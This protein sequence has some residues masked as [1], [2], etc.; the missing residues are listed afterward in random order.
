MPAKLSH[1]TPIGDSF[2]YLGR[3]FDFSLKG[4]LEKHDI[5]SKLT[6]LLKI[7]SELKIRPQTKLKIFDRFIVSQISSSLRICNFTATWVSETLDPLCIKIIR[8]WIEVAPSCSLLSFQPVTV[9]FTAQLVKKSPSKQSQL[10]PI[11]TWLLKQC[12]TLLAPFLTRL[13][14]ISIEQGSVPECM[15]MAIVAPLLKKSILDP[16]DISNFRPVSNLSFFSKL[17]ERTIS[18]QLTSYLESGIMLPQY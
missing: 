7:T 13:I 11:P 16:A 4:E 1:P 8:L 2:R 17:L 6:K 3:V 15:K 10:D 14:N 9:E 5:V 18:H 12:V